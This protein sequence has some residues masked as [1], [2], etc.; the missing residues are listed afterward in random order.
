MILAWRIIYATDAHSHKCA[1]GDAAESQHMSL[2]ITKK[3]SVLRALV[4][5]DCDPA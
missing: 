3:Q 1:P 5:A 2:I 4:P